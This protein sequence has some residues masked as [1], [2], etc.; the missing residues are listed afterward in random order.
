MF[1]WLCGKCGKFIGIGIRS[2]RKCKRRRSERLDAR[3][4]E[5]LLKLQARSKKIR[6]GRQSDE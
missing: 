3:L 6:K 4:I 2:C 1:F 5:Q